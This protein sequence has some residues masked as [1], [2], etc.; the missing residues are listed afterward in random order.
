[1]LK[2]RVK[3]IVVFINT[4]MELK[5]NTRWPL[6][7]EVDSFL[8]VL[9]GHPVPRS[10]ATIFSP[11]EML[12][13]DRIF[14]D[15]RGQ[16]LE[17]KDYAKTLLGLTRS[18]KLA[19]RQP[20]GGGAGPVGRMGPAEL[21]ELG[22]E[23]DSEYA[24]LIRGP[25]Y[26]RD[27]YRTVYNRYFGVEPGHEVEILWVYNGK[28]NAFLDRLPADTREKLDS[29]PSL[30]SFPRT[31][32]FRSGKFVERQLHEWGEAM[33]KDGFL[34][35]TVKWVKS[36]DLDGLGMIDMTPAQINLLSALSGWGVSLLEDELL[37]MVPQARASAPVRPNLQ[38][39]LDRTGAATLRGAFA[40]AGKHDPSIKPESGMSALVDSLNQ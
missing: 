22:L 33:R 35:G 26:Y 25:V 13:H 12:N 23:P 9:F 8:T 34:A 1:M 4:D 3:K 38:S 27:T 15:G 20:P 10:L 11:S 39:I 36:I 29:D 19:N 16:V 40:T 14:G 5:H 7:K 17:K 21:A 6:D 24:G 32:T 30:A 2:R 18:A 37:D 31:A 28:S